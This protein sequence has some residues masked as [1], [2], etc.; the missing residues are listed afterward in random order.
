[1]YSPIRKYQQGGE[2][3]PEQLMQQI[4]QMLQQ[5]M[6]PQQIMEQLQQMGIQPQQAQQMIQQV[7]Q[8]MQQAPEQPQM[9]QGGYNP[10]LL[11]DDSTMMMKG[12]MHKMP[13]GIMMKNSMMQSGGKIN[14]ADFPP[15]R[16]IMKREE[17]Y[18][19]ANPNIIVYQDTYGDGR[20]DITY[21]DKKTG[22]M[23]SNPWATNKDSS[24]NR[25]V[26]GSLDLQ[27]P[28]F[29]PMQSVSKMKKGGMKKWSY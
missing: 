20:K 5:Q 19:G 11:D 21:Q 25:S 6:S 3:N 14:Y 26:T 22:K 24:I 7:A 15:E 16:T 1:M 18:K 2:A 29:V 8:S 28:K 23:M 12:G 13:N 9:Q 27:N 17:L 4:A 10:Y